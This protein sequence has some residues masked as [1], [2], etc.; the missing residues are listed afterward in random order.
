MEILL[1]LL[2]L[3]IPVASIAWTVTHEELFR[4]FHEYCA[5][6]STKGKNIF[7]RKFFYMFTCEYCFS[8]YVAIFII[9]ITGYK[10]YF[11]GWVGFLLA[12]FSLAF[13]SNVYMSLFGKVRLD[14]KKENKEIQ[15]IEKI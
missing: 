6:R 12:F 10:L 2:I 7:S 5:K 14:I 8:H 9:L 15:K 3:A 4:E 13:I 1:V 11:S